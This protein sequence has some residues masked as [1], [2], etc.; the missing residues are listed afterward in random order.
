MVCSICIVPDSVQCCSTGLSPSP[1]ALAVG[2]NIDIVNNIIRVEDFNLLK[3]AG[4]M[5]FGQ[6]TKFIVIDPTEIPFVNSW[7]F[8]LIGLFLPYTWY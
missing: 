4:C 6:Q 8:Y 7:S 5:L 1:I 3:K 2:N